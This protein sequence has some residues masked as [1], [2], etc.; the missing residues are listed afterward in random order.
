MDAEKWWK[1]GRNTKTVYRNKKHR[2]INKFKPFKR[3]AG[4]SR[5]FLACQKLSGLC[6][7]YGYSRAAE[8]RTILD[9][10]DRAVCQPNGVA[11]AFWGLQLITKIKENEMTPQSVK[12]SCDFVRSH[13]AMATYIREADNIIE[14]WN[15]YLF[16]CDTANNLLAWGQEM[17]II[18]LT[19]NS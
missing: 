2:Q 17:N 14:A 6:L 11:Q 12:A 13:H 5:F 3:Q 9:L 18:K 8:L 1:I 4:M 10:L 7:W 19:K 15:R 16:L